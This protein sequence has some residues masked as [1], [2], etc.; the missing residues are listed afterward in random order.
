[1]MFT[2]CFQLMPLPTGSYF[3]L[4]DIFRLNLA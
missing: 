3:V 4:N 2:Q 1:M